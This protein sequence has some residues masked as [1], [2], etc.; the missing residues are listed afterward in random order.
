MGLF[1]YDK[2]TDKGLYMPQFKKGERLTGRDSLNELFNDSSSFFVYPFKLVW[3]KTERSGFPARIVVSVP[4]RR[5]KRAV[6]RNL[7]RRRI[8]ESYRL[9][10]S[11]FYEKLNEKDVKLDMAIIYVA[12]KEMDYDSIDRKFTTLLKKFLSEL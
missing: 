2:Y 9:Q 6:K 4:K 12:D 10:K 8:K 5:F 11:E 3:K 1:V 7:I